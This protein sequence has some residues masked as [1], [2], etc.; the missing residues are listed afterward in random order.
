MRGLLNDQSH[1]PL[2]SESGPKCEELAL[3]IYCPTC[4]PIATGERTSR[5]GR[6]VQIL[7]Q[8]DFAH[9]SKQH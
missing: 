4:H 6:F 1:V 9:L 2:M 5:I 3:S 8:K 7:L